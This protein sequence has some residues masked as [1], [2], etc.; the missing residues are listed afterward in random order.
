MTNNKTN[1]CCSPNPKPDNQKSPC[2]S[3]PDNQK[4]QC[5]SP[6]SQNSSPDSSSAPVEVIDILEIKQVQP[7]ILFPGSLIKKQI[8]P[9]KPVK[10]SSKLTSADKFGAF[11]V[12]WGISRMSYT[13][14]PGLYELGKPDKNSEVLV[15]ANYKLT[16]D[17]LRSS[18]PKQN[19]W[20]LVLDTAGV[21]VW[22][23][24]G[25]GTFGT[26]ELINRINITSL[27]EYV[28]HKRIIVPQLGAPGVS[29]FKVKEATG[30]NVKFGP[31]KANDIPE[32]LESKLKVTPQ[33][34]KKDF[35]LSERFILIPVELVIALKLIFIMQIA[36]MFFSIFGGSNGYLYNLTHTGLLAVIA[37]FSATMAGAVLFPILL[38]FL[39]GRAFSLKSI[40]I[41]IGVSALV[42]V[43]AGNGFG[44]WTNR[45]ESVAWI[46]MI[47][48]I[49]AFFAMN[50]T[51]S[52]TYTSLSGVKK[53]MKIALPLQ[54]VF[55]GLGFLFWVVSRFAA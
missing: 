36:F 25:K 53:E 1:S 2:C 52:S 23:A 5:C 24:A 3:P 41:G 27:N 11:K 44:N 16:F 21:N 43:L 4:S 18:L 15:T 6:Q 22:C 7:G 30:F 33:M 37:L 48:A 45:F 54:I 28:N 42:I 14:E 35:P 46:L 20:L 31:I 29:G 50:F 39:P 34:R 55:G 13:V 51:G 47:S 40:P 38:P 12:R 49:T 9:A 32:Y 8:K 19:L 26:N 10:I 17:K